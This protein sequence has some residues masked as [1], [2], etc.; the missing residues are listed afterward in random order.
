MQNVIF[1]FDISL[2]HYIINRELRIK[3][4]WS[5]T[6]LMFSMSIVQV[7]CGTLRETRGGDGEDLASKRT[8]KCGAGSVSG[9]EPGAMLGIYDGVPVMVGMEATIRQLLQVCGSY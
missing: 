2:G 3:C 8:E 4:M 5:L 1:L 9:E 7:Y 6:K